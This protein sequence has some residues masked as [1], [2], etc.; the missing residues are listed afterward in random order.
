MS[1]GGNSLKTRLG[2]EVSF[3]GRLMG[4][5]EGETVAKLGIEDTRM[6]DVERYHRLLYWTVQNNL[7]SFG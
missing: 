1:K 5:P 4:G 6:G 3:S 7:R 2:I